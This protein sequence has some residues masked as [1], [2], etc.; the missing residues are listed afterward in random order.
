MFT[1]HNLPKYW[2]VLLESIPKGTVRARE[3]T[4]LFPCLFMAITLSIVR[5]S[6]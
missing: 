6:R 5:R 4:E 2:M 3:H 1:V